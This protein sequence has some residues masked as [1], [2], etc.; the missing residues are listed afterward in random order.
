MHTP[1][2]T[3]FLPPLSQPQRPRVAAAP[4][5]GTGCCWRRR[6]Q[7]APGCPAGAVGADPLGPR[8]Q[9]VRTLLP[10]GYPGSRATEAAPQEPAVADRMAQRLLLLEPPARRRRQGEA[11]GHRTRPP[12]AEA[13]PRTRPPEAEAE[14]HTRLR[15]V[16]VLQ[17]PP[18]A[19]AER[20][21]LAEP[22]RQETMDPTWEPES[23]R[24]QSRSGPQ[25]PQPRPDRSRGE[26]SRACRSRRAG[27]GPPDGALPRL[28]KAKTASHVRLCRQPEALEGPHGLSQRKT[29]CRL[30]KNSAVEEET[31]A[32]AVEGPRRR[33]T[34]T[35]PQAQAQALRVRSW[36]A[37]AALRCS[38]GSAAPACRGS[39]R[40]VRAQAAPPLR[41]S[42]P[43]TL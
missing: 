6:R 31:G 26:P 15:E 43:R 17:G 11:A 2:E 9:A 21:R 37:E 29:T 10:R 24:R 32:P 40:S 39:P 33:R 27:A 19:E 36:S 12:E 3:G 20:R 28:W 22:K 23:Q 14:H 1:A 30:L 8:R 25:R 4:E 18:R 38:C 42:T 34:P 7:P 13:E 35:A 16:A 5:P 41:S